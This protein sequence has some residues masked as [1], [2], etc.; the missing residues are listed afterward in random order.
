MTLT[1]ASVTKGRKK[2]GGSIYDSKGNDDSDV[3]VRDSAEM[4]TVV[5]Q[6]CLEMSWC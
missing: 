1:K 6:N 4:P 2:A 3:S 5:W